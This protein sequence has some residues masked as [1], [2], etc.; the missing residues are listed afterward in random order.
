M[1]NYHTVLLM[2]LFLF[3]V[4]WPY[5]QFLEYIDGAWNSQLQRRDLPGC[6]VKER[7]SVLYIRPGRPEAEA[8]GKKCSPFT[9]M[10]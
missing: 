7:Y 3:A 8:N 5:E 6:V 2:P 1:N 9:G 10:G 4:D